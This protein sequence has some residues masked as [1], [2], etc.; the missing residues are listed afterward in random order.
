[1]LKER[2]FPQ[3]PKENWDTF[4]TRLESFTE[5][6]RV[7]IRFAYQL[8]KS[9]HRNKWRLS[10]ER[11]F[12]HLRGTALILLDECKIQDPSVICAALLH[13]SLE[14]TSIFGNPIKTQYSKWISEANKLIS[15]IFSPQTAEIV[16]AVT[17]PVVDRIEILDEAQAKS[18]KWEK[19]K[20]A[21]PEALLVKMADRLHNLRTFYPKPGE[22]TPL[23][24]IK[25]TEKILLPIFKRVLEKHPLEGRQLLAEIDKAI[26]RLRLKC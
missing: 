21:S 8:A 2:R 23:E 16:I 15:R 20:K 10:G 5:E 9:A 26:R 17:E 25:E 11:Y 12:E 4:Q 19:L 7:D 14:D 22:K 3:S 24:R 1:M 18:I 6:D 13:D